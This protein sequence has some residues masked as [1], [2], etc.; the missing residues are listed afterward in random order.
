MSASPEKKEYSFNKNY[1]RDLRGY[2]GKPPHAA[3]PGEARIAVQFVLNYEEGAENN[4][5]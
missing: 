5:L 4:V 3:W 2:A 1:P